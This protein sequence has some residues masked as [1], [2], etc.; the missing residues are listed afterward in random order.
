MTVDNDKIDFFL[1]IVYKTDWMLY[2]YTTVITELK[3][4]WHNL[5]Q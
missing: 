2:K 4:T 5:K 3:K 1:K